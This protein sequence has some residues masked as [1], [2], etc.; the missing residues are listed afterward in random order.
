MNE[1]CFQDSSVTRTKREIA[2]KERNSAPKMSFLAGKNNGLVRVR[3]YQTI[4]PI[5]MKVWRIIV[6]LLPV[7]VMRA[8]KQMCGAKVPPAGL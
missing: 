7:I 8:R 6:L 5:N 4:F 1:M 2:A 3:V